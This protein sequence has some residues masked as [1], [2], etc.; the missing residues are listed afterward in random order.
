MQGFIISLNKVKEEDLIVTIVS[1]E[2][3]DTLYR[4]YGARHSVINLGYKI[5]YEREFSGK[6]TIGRLKDV[7]HIGYKWIYDSK[8]LRLWQDFTALFYKHLKDVEELDSFYFDLLEN[9]S[10]DWDKKNPKRVAIESYV[11]LLDQEGRLHKELVCFL[12]SKKIEGE[13][14]LIRAY[15]PTHKECTHT[16]SIAQNAFTELFENKSTLFMNDKE[17]DRLW[18]VLLEGL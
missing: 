18:L 5:D 6:S 2:N 11:K 4:F 3:L 16:L 10:K 12:C 7:I 17:V 14:S 8:R 13:I 9:A 15:L 1:R